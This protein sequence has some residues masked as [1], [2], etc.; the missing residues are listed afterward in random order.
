MLIGMFFTDIIV[1]MYC[2]VFC[3]RVDFS[4]A[5]FQVQNLNLINGSCGLIC[6]VLALCEDSHTQKEKKKPYFLNNTIF[7]GYVP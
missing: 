1:A 4:G 7:E 5:E 6:L 3:V 2:Y